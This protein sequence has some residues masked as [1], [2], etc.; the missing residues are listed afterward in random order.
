MVKWCPLSERS[1]LS[2]WN[3]LYQKGNFCNKIYF[4]S[5]LFLLNMNFITMKWVF[6]PLGRKLLFE[7]EFVKMIF[8][9]GKYLFKFFFVFGEMFGK[10]EIFLINYKGLK[11]RFTTI[12]HLIIFMIISFNHEIRIYC[13]IFL[14]L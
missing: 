14:V 10:I 1:E 5:V 6:K 13:N 12:Q 2:I 3:V 11:G 7:F 4:S 9:T 8:S